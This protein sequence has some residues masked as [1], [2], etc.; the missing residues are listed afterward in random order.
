MITKNSMFA[1]MFFGC[2]LVAVVVVHTAIGQ[3]RQA[4]A[5]TL[6]TDAA[7]SY[8]VSLWTSGDPDVAEKVCFMYTHNAKKMG[9]FDNVNLIVWGPSAHLLANNTS[10]QN[11]V[12]AMMNDGVVVEACKACADSYGVTSKLTS[13]GVTV[14]Y[15]G[16]PLTNMLKQNK[17]VLTF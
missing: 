3:D 2:A 7:N 16:M 10:L 9:W 17:K 15:M 11:Q 13:L 1:L 14:K 5:Y 8:L 4:K 12:L 6:T